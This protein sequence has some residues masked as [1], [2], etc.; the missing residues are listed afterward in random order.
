[1]LTGDGELIVLPVK[2]L[3]ELKH[4]PPAVISSLDAQFEVRISASFGI[5]SLYV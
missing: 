5:P 4:L 1:M 2:Y 3:G